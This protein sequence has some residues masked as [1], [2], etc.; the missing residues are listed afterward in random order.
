RVGHVAGISWQPAAGPA[1][2]S[3]QTPLEQRVERGGLAFAGARQQLERRLELGGR[4]RPI[5][6]LTR[7]VWAHWG[8]GLGEYDSPVVGY[9][10]LQKWHVHENVEAPGSVQR[11][12][13]A[14]G[15]NR[16]ITPNPLW[17]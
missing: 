16:A 9:G 4:G 3:R 11:G 6:G 5:P 13:S 14:A 15:P 10:G 1:T 7:F 8:E 12:R 17:C 2:Q